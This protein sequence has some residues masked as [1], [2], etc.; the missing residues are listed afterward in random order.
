[1]ASYRVFVDG[2]FCRDRVRSALDQLSSLGEVGV[3]LS[4]SGNGAPGG[5]QSSLRCKCR[6]VPQELIE[7]A[8]C[9]AHTETNNSA[10]GELVKLFSQQ[11][12]RLVR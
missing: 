3:A 8:V 7:N 9:Q 5:Y 1:M 11:G 12:A 2:I 6:A 4:V 10:R